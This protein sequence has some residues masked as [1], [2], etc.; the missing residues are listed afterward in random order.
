MLENYKKLQNGLIKQDVVKPFNYDYEY[1]DNYNKLGELGPRMAY[2]RLGYI[3]G[4]LDEP[5]ESIMDIGYGN[6]D[7]IRACTN[8]IPACYCNDISTYDVPEGSTFIEN[9]YDQEV[10][11]IT[12]FDVLEHLPDIYVIKDFKTKYLVVSM[13][14]CHYFDDVWF[15][16]W[17]HRKE[18]EH[19]W[20]FNSESLISFMD[21]VGY[22]P[23]T[24]SNIEDTIRKNNQ[25]YSN[26]LTGVF[27]KR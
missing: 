19:L 25:D 1:A 24:I 26:I 7:F 22:D 3:L 16:N 21:E 27:K 12:M 11:V 18:D 15:K 9:I 10:D 5:I 20:H 4:A 13:P 17:K 23:I 2:L 14:Y 8:I 6:G